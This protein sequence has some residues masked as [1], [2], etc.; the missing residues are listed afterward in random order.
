M[1][2]QASPKYSRILG[3]FIST[4]ACL[5]AAPQQASAA[6]EIVLT[7]DQSQFLRLPMAPATIVVGNPAIADV[8]SDGSSL[9]FHPKG[10]GV[11]NVLALDGS[12]RKLGDYLVR[13]IYD[14]AYSVT[15][16]A[17]GNRESY[18]CRNNCEPTM[19][20]GDGKDYFDLYFGQAQDKF[21]LANTQ[22][23]AGDSST[24]PAT[25]TVTTTAVGAPP[26]N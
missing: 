21:D 11:T 24:A 19:R 1:L 8:T 7:A 18:S 2:R 3:F 9:F 14:D 20:I 4:L 13:V 6:Q 12:G 17:P 22:A 16:Y 10:F 26:P 5:A 25:A 15:I 23:T